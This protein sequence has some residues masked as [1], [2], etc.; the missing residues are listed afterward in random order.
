[1]VS[2]MIT[3]DIEVSPLSLPIKIK[4]AER[5]IMKKVIIPI[6]SIKGID[7]VARVNPLMQDR[8]FEALKLSIAE[9]G[10]EVPIV[11]CRNLIIDGRSRYN[12][13]KELGI[14]NIAVEIM[15]GNSSIEIKKKR[16]EVME[17]RRHQTKTQLACTA[18]SIWNTDKPNDMTQADFIKTKSISQANFTNANWIY[19]NNKQVFQALAKGQSVR[20]SET[21]E[22]KISES[23]NAVVKYLKSLEV[24]V[25]TK[26]TPHVGIYTSDKRIR[27]A[28]NYHINGLLEELNRMELP[29]GELPAIS[30]DIATI[31]YRLFK[32]KSEMD[33]TTN[34][35]IVGSKLEES[36]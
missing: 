4:R 33:T 28:V 29:S 36:N 25:D 19:K 27:E 30:K 20:I 6:N 8:E 18:V 1:M 22:Y 24:G 17:T 7:K 2:G 31:L 16:V 35:V 14:E 5:F 3:I 26:D 9:S 34:K 10:L 15:A 23:L 11:I 12:A 32:D 13:C 21:D